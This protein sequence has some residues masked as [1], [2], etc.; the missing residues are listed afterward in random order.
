MEN[1]ESVTEISKVS[2]HEAILNFLDYF[3]DTRPRP[4]CTKVVNNIDTRSLKN[5]E[6][7]VS[8][9]L[10]TILFRSCFNANNALARSIS[11]IT[12]PNKRDFIKAQY[13]N[14]LLKTNEIILCN[15][16]HEAL[17]LQ[18]AGK[19]SVFLKDLEI[20]FL[21][22][23]SNRQKSDTKSEKKSKKIPETCFQQ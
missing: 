14:A 8:N 5:Y 6:T 3:L 20:V 10:R 13:F 15:Y 21:I 1:K 12:N 4:F 23:D 17:I 18:D 16:Y 19:N 22:I 7:V 2:Y 11:L 9:Y